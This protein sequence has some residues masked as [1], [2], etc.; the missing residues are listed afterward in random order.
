MN[1]LLGMAGITRG[2]ELMLTYI[3]RFLSCVLLS[4]IM[5]QICPADIALPKFFSDHMVLQQNADF[6]VWGVAEPNQT[7]VVRFNGSEVKATAN[8]SGNFS[9][10]IKTPAAGGPYRLEVSDQGNT[11][12]VILDDVMVGEVWLCAGQSNMSW[13]VEKSAD[14]AA[15]ILSANNYNQIRLYTVEAHA[16]DEPLEDVAKANPWAICSANNVKNFSAVAFFFGR[17][18]AKTLKGTPIGLINASWGGTR[19]EA[20]CSRDSLNTVDELGPLLDYWAEIKGPNDRNRPGTLFNGMISPLA[21]YPLR[22][23]VLYQGEGNV[24]RG[25]QYATL[26]P[27]LIADWRQKFGNSKLPF[28]YAQLA[29]HRYSDYPIEALPELWDAQLKTAKTVAHVAMATTMDLG[30]ITDLHPKNKQDVGKR[31]AMLALTDTYLSKLAMTAVNGPLYES[32][33]IDENVIRVYFG[34]SGDGLKNL[35]ESKTIETFLIC[36]SDEVFYPATVKQI[37]QNWVDI[38]SPKVPSPASVR[39]CWND[40]A[41]SLLGNSDGLPAFPFRTDDFRLSSEDSEF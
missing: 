23:V 24:G 8:A 27:T 14:A 38:F 2:T 20:W 1:Q 4:A 41:M 9:A 25:K 3:S 30:N 15:E 11:I 32:M 33:K 29:P 34:C 40:T 31:L 7:L 17:D 19:C 18:L 6:P 21:R 13:P 35:S 36:G 5:M 39:Y 26:L 16:A 12:G 28:Y 22:G 37:G 10:Y